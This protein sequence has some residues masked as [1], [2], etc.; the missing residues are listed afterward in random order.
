MVTERVCPR[1]QPG[2]DKVSLSY[3]H[4]IV[5]EKIREAQK[6]GAFDNLPGR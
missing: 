2:E 6:A 5:E 4:R 1:D 3:F